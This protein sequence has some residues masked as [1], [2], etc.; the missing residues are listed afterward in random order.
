MY[1]EKIATAIEVDT[2]APLPDLRQAFEQAKARVGR[3]N[4][5]EQILVRQA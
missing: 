3:V 1:I 5:P 4:T 2:G